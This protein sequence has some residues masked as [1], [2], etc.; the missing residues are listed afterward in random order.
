M[1]RK[2]YAV[3]SISKMLISPRFASTSV[4]VKY[5][6]FSPHGGTESPCA[7]YAG[8]TTDHFVN[9]QLEGEMRLG[10]DLNHSVIMNRKIC[11]YHQSNRTCAILYKSN[12]ASLLKLQIS[13][14]GTVSRFVQL[15]GTLETGESLANLISRCFGK[16]RVK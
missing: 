6:P 16:Y 12:L 15:Q 4:K 1:L 10:C 3:D 9:V 8:A 5:T 13:L 7:S 2:G 11:V 14:K